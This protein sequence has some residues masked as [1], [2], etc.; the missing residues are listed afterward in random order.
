MISQSNLIKTSL[1][2][3]PFYQKN[4]SLE[5]SGETLITLPDSLFPAANFSYSLDVRV[6]R[7]DN[8]SKSY[9][10][11][12][13]FFDRIEDITYELQNDSILFIA[14][15]NGKLIKSQASISG[16]DRFGYSS[17]PGIVILPWKEKINPYYESYKIVTDKLTKTIHIEDDHSL[18][19]C[20]SVI[21]NDSLKFKIINPRNL[22]FTWFLF[23]ET[24]L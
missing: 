8:E 6:I 10:Q 17:N 7:S 13:E 1:S 9:H 21:V 4:V 14:K 3:I 5:Q 2:G 16:R 23:R 12:I 24:A 15:E 11:N 20:E 19:R 18:V 22:T